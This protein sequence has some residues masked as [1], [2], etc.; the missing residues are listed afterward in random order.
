MRA[1]EVSGQAPGGK[2]TIL[3]E[4]LP[5]RAPIV[6]QMFPIYACNFACRYCVFSVDK[7]ERGFIS[8]KI[9]MD[10]GLYH[11][12]IDELS[13]FPDK[14][15]VLRFVGM[16]EP[17]LHAQIADMVE[18]AVLHD[19]AGRV[20]I[21]TNASLLT[22]KLSDALISAG[23]SRLVVSLQGTTSEKYR[24]VCG[25]SIP[26]EKIIDNLK[27]FFDNKGGAHLHIKIIDYALQGE[28]DGKKFYELF[29]DICDTIGIERAG[30][31]F[32][33]VDYEPVL[34]NKDMSLTQFGL[35]VSEVH[36]CPQPFFT[37]QINPDGKVVPCYSIAYPTIVGDCNRQSLHE[38]WNGKTFQQFR[39]SML[40]GA[41]KVC[42][43]CADCNII[44][45]RLF[46]EDNLNNDAE[47]LK[48]YYEEYIHHE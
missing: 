34:K 44:K 24:E 17:L 30:P 33:G 18:Y 6:V 37:L 21:L 12:C 46:P 43:T 31:I 10:V 15:K 5:L 22:P 16:G 8:D 39:L 47:R 27:Y 38:I 40:D 48:A 2:R 14:M 41:R 19:V 25:A 45:H 3:A 9:V 13:M 42:E 36:V 4:V 35:P 23:L 28:D 1:R 29:G 7:A 32:P 11:K 26:I 20:E